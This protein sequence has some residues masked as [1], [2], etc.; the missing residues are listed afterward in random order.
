MEVKGIMEIFGKNLS[1]YIQLKQT[2]FM[3]VQGNYLRI[4]PDRLLGLRGRVTSVKLQKAN[5]EV[6]FA[7]QPCQ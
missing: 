5:T 6:R 3:S 4:N 7:S 1:D 2:G